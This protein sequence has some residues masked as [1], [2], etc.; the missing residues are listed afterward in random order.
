[1][2][3]PGLLHLFPNNYNNSTIVDVAGNVTL[4]TTT[5]RLDFI[6]YNVIDPTNVNPY[7]DLP[8]CIEGQYYDTSSK[9]CISKSHD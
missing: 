6:G 8:T 9:T 4:Y 1:M 3:Y 2:Y 5:T 7:N